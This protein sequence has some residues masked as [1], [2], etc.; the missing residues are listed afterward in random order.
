MELDADGQGQ[1]NGSNLFVK[2]FGQVA[3][4]IKFSPISIK[5][6]DK[7]PEIT[8]K[9]GGNLLNCAA[10][11]PFARAAVALCCCRAV[12]APL[13]RAA[14]RSAAAALSSL[15]LSVAAVAPP[16]LVLLC[17]L[18]ID[19]C[20]AG[21]SAMAVTVHLPSDFSLYFSFSQ[22]PKGEEE[23]E[24]EFEEHDA[25]PV[26]RGAVEMRRRHG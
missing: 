13:A 23:E 2:F 11:T 20:I 12:V 14:R 4:R 25:V 16:T 8:Q 17:S 10:V 6:W 9:D 24:E 1:D 5:R 7:M 18:S 3:R 15:L 26:L 19:G 22:I 21:I